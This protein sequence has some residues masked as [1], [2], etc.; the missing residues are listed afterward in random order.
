MQLP[1]EGPLRA[2][3]IIG[4]LPMAA[5]TLFEKSGSPTSSA[6]SRTGPPCSISIVSWS[7]K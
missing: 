2:R 1:L 3:P 4:E 6:Q 7:T 5:Q